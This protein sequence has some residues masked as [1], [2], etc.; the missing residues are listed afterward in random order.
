[1]DDYSDFSKTQS[2]LCIRGHFKTPL[3]K[4]FSIEILEV[5]DDLLVR[6]MNKNNRVRR[7]NFK[8]TQAAYSSS[9]FEGELEHCPL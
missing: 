8:L 7:T 6:G 1:M 5:T 2:E 4:C 9:S 3:K